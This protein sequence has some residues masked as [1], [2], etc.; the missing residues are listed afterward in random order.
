MKAEFYPEKKNPP[1]LIVGREVDSAVIACHDGGQAGAT[2]I[3]FA[4]LY[5]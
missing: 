3:E 4:G 5:K 2:L 1:R